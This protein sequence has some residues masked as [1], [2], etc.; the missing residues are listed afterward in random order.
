VIF[1]DTFEVYEFPSVPVNVTSKKVAITFPFTID[2]NNSPSRGDQ[3]IFEKLYQ[4]QLRQRDI[5]NPVRHKNIP[6]QQLISK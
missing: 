6:D 5:A 2:T 1:A 4:L 3:T